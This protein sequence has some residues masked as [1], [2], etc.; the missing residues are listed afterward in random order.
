MIIKEVPN[1][2]Y[3][4]KSSLDALSWLRSGDFAEILNNS[5]HAGRGIYT[6]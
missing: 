3:V 4:R 6:S 5:L 1:T 2:S